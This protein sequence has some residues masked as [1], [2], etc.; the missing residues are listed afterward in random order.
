MKTYYE[1]EKDVMGMM[2]TKICHENKKDTNI[3]HDSWEML[4]YQTIY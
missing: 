2:G 3:C 4:I 1:N